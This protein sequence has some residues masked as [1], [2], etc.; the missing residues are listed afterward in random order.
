[1]LKKEGDED[2]AQN[3]MRR[4]SKNNQGA[5]FVFQSFGNQGKGDLLLFLKGEN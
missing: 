3:R 4:F 1:M 2:C 5:L